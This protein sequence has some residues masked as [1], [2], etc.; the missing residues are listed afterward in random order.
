[1]E[2]T[3]WLRLITVFI[4]YFGAYPEGVIFAILIMN[5]FVWLID[6]FQNPP[7]R[8]SGLSLL[9]K[10]GGEMKGRK[11]KMLHLELPPLLKKIF[12]HPPKQKKSARRPPSPPDTRNIFK[13]RLFHP[14]LRKIFRHHLFRPTMALFLIT[15]VVSLLLSEVHSFTAAR[16]ETIR[17]EETSKALA[18]VFP[19][20][21][22][23]SELEYQTDD[24]QITGLLA[25]YADSAMVGYCVNVEPV[26]F[27]GA[28]DL[29]VGVDLNGS[30]TGVHIVSH[31]E[32]PGLGSRAEAPDF[33]NQFVGKSGTVKLNAGANSVEAITGATVTSAALTNGVNAALALVSSHSEQEAAYE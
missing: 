26:G 11:R 25:A 9:P 23:F 19:D 15:L 16:I 4:R 21:K 31:S 18:I 8:V 33:L 12:R 3:A 20:A 17:A 2:S 14:D 5:A 6:G 32:T 30:V 29:I 28:I 10:G 27:G 22:E 13:H 7:F 1:V 24:I